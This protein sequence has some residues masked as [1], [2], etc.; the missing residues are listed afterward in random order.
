MQG[1]IEKAQGKTS[2]IL[3]AREA[4]MQTQGIV[5]TS[6]NE[7]SLQTVGLPDMRPSD[8]LVE[9]ELSGVSVGTEL[10]ALTGQRPAGDTTFPCIPGYQAVGQVRVS[11]PESALQPGER[12]FFT[13]SR[14][15]EPFSTGNWMGSHLRFAVMDAAEHPAHG[16]WVRLPEGLT[17]EDAVLSALAAV[18]GIGL[19]QVAIQPGD[20]CVVLGQG[21]IGQTAAQ[22]ARIRGAEVLVADIAPN[23][24]EMARQYSADSVWNPQTDGDLA[25]EVRRRKPNGADLVIEASGN[26]TLIPLAIDLVRRWGSVVLQGWYPGE[27]AFDFHKAHGRRPILHIACGMDR[28]A[29]TQALRWVAEGKMHLA[30]LLTHRFAPEQASEAYAMMRERPG[31]FLGV[32]FDWRR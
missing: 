28:E 29:N 22:T 15:V 12:I 5:F 30:P 10:W 7:A 1:G 24:L 16:Y 32:A 26:K 9:V 4:T 31:D 18:T 23:R 6:I 17:P 13:K 19:R 21:V 8:A 25:A 11:G 3:H 27:V 14:L 20:L 2:S